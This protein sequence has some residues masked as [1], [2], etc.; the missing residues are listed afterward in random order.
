M[1]EASRQ[2]RPASMAPWATSRAR[3]FANQAVA[4]HAQGPGSLHGK[5]HERAALRADG[6]RGTPSRWGWGL[7][8]Q[9]PGV[10]EVELR[11][12]KG[13][14]VADKERGPQP[15]PAPPLAPSAH[16]RPGDPSS[17]ALQQSRLRLARQS[18]QRSVPAFPPGSRGTERTW[19]QLRTRQ[20][21]SV[22]STRP[23]CSSSPSA[24]PRRALL[25]PSR[26]R[27]S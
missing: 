24:S 14:W 21:A 12:P 6:A 16:R 26:S 8:P 15:K 3:T 20:P 19:C 18:R 2:R 7:C 17:G 1:H 13:V 23:A 25:T 10:W 9:T 11:C 4:L 22:R 27:S 5:W